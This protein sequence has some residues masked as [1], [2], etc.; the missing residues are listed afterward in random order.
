M[1]AVINAPPFATCRRGRCWEVQTSSSWTVNSYSLHSIVDFF[2][3]PQ[4]ALLEIWCSIH[5]LG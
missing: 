1:P 5:D 4:D 2:R 3:L